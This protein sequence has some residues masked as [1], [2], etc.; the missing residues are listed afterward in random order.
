MMKM[1][2]PLIACSL[3]ALV[4][5]GCGTVREI[6]RTERRPHTAMRGPAFKRLV[7]TFNEANNLA[8]RADRY[9]KALRDAGSVDPD[10]LLEAQ[11]LAADLAQFADDI[12]WSLA[13]L[14]RMTWH[15]T[16]MDRYWDRFLTLY[17]E[18][19]DFML[20]YTDD[21]VRKP[22]PKLAL[23]NQEEYRDLHEYEHHDAEWS[24][25]FTPIGRKVYD[26]QIEKQD[27]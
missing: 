14:Q 3:I 1:M 21:K 6:D 5:S 19:E 27:Q 15:R 12:E 2:K 18:D 24:T 20:A 9:A 22:S 23:K 4:L 10:T 25:F 26:E 16:E 17:P 7:L 8:Y 13:N 11:E